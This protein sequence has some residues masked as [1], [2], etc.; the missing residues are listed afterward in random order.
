MKWKGIRQLGTAY[1]LWYVLSKTYKN[2][3]SLG[4]ECSVITKNISHVT[5]KGARQLDVEC[6]LVDREALKVTL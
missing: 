3:F 1:C 4:S 5:D 6:L 2:N